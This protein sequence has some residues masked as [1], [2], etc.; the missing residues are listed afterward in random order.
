[1]L[2]KNQMW[3]IVDLVI[4]ENTR[5]NEAIKSFGDVCLQ[6]D[7]ASIV[8]NTLIENRK[9]LDFATLRLMTIPTLRVFI[10]EIIE[11][12]RSDAE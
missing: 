10:K 4:R 8:N 7:Y 2:D 5:E 1:M 3:E 9:V 12:L 6:I 11:I